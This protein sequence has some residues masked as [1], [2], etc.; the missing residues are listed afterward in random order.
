M[1]T[2]ERWITK[3]GSKLWIEEDVLHVQSTSHG[4][5]EFV[6]DFWHVH[7]VYTSKYSEDETIV[8]MVLR[9]GR[10]INLGRYTSDNEAISL[11][12]AINEKI[13]EDK[14]K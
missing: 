1:T 5:S 8:Q 11:R 6:L 10:T 14:R 4:S 2:T 7:K 12:E 9:D 13:K 3:R